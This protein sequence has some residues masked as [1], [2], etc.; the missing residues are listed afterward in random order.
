VTI[1]DV[2]V[3]PLAIA[4]RFTATA[5]AATARSVRS[6]RRD[7]ARRGAGGHPHGRAHRAEFGEIPGALVVERNVL[8]WR[9]DPRS[10]ARLPVAG[11][12]VRTG[13]PATLPHL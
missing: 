12:Y 13:K 2:R 1:T 6:G 7:E 9:F 11:S 5:P 4:R 10:D 3:D 8:E